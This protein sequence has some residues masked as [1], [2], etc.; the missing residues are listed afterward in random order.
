M[1]TGPTCPMCRRRN[2]CYTPCHGMVLRQSSHRMCNPDKSYQHKHKTEELLAVRPALLKSAP[3]KKNEQNGWNEN[4]A[5]RTQRIN[6]SQLQWHYPVPH[7]YI[8]RLEITQV[9]DDSNPNQERRGSKQNAA[10]IIVCEILRNEKR[11]REKWVK[12]LT[13]L[14]LLTLH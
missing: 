1:F 13:P 9:S 10:Q 2:V 6:E 12:Y 5:I 7:P 4:V 3:E 11:E 8:I 14:S